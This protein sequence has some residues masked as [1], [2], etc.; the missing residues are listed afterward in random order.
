MFLRSWSPVGRFAAQV[1]LGLLDLIPLTS[2]LVL[3]G[4]EAVLGGAHLLQ[5]PKELVAGGGL[6]AGT[7]GGSWPSGPPQPS[8]AAR[9]RA[10]RAIARIPRTGSKA[11]PSPYTPKIAYADYLPDK[12]R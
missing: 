6:A 10:H 4:R 12:P 8:A 9:N 11:R 5:E 1:R 7:S 2:R 3:S